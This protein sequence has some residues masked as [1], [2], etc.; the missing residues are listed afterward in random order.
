MNVLLIDSATRVA[1]CAVYNG[2]KYIYDEVDNEITHSEKLMP[3]IDKTLKSCNLNIDNIDCLAVTTGPGSFT[4]IRIGIATIK[5]LALK[6]N[7]KIFSISNLDLMVC[8][9][10]IDTS[11]KVS[12]ID[13][14]HERIYFNVFKNIDGKYVPVIEAKNLQIIEALEVVKEIVKENEVSFIIDNTETFEE[15]IKLKFSNSDIKQKSI[16]LK[17]FL[18]NILNNNIISTTYLDLDATYARLSEAE[19]T[20]YG[21]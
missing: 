17:E 1:R 13:A 8:G 20:I 10:N 7:L 12:M 16:S 19:R 14:K 6:N 3:L 4:G 2:T 11:Y 21:E 15:K 18:K 5:A 9:E